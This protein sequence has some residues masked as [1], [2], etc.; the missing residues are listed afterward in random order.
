MF[1]LTDGSF[2]AD[3]VTL[4]RLIEI[5][6]HVQDA[7]ISGPPDLLNKTKFDIEAKPDPSFVAGTSQQ[8]SGGKN[9]DDQVMLKSLLADEFKL[10]MHSETRTVPAYDLVT[11][12]GGAKLQPAG[13]QPRNMHFGLGELISSGAPLELL[14]AQLSAR[15][16]VPVLDKTGLKGNYA[17]NLRWTPGPSETEKLKV[18]GEPMP[19]E[20]PAAANGPSLATALQEQLGL[21]LQPNTEPVRVLV[22]DHAEMPSETQSESQ[23][24][25][26]PGS[27]SENTTSST[28]FRVP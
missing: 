2:V 22:V 18:S 10:V 6:Y 16:G 11:D 28:P 23:S 7:Q 21:K 27:Q 20:P 17:F 3:G 8:I 15:L 26:Q 9:F 24:T 5:A 1:S 14:A 4:Q 13:E 12:E 19:P 25:N